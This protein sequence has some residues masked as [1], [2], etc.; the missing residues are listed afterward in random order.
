[1]P[2]SGFKAFKKEYWSQNQLYELTIFP[3]EIPKKVK[4]DTIN[5]RATL[6]K[7]L[8]DNIEPIWEKD[9]INPIAPYNAFV[10]NYG[11]FLLTVDNW[12][13]LDYWR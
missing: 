12:Y 8:G 3:T 10:T 13:S 5:C 4:G 1:M 9:L 7:H 6:W 2:T 11:K